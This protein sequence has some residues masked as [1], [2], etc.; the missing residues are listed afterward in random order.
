MHLLNLWKRFNFLTIDQ[1]AIS[2]AEV[3]QIV[4]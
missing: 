2:V 4:Q 1:N 3:D